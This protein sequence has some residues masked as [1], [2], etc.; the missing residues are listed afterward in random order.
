MSRRRGLWTIGGIIVPVLTLLLAG[1]VWAAPPGASATGGEPL[2]KPTMVSHA[3]F[4]GNTIDC[5]MTNNGA[6]VDSRVYSSSAMM[7]P[8]GTDKFI[9]Y[10]S[11]LWLLGI[12]HD[13]GAIYSAS[14]EYSSELKEGPWPYANSYADNEAYRIYKINGDGTGDWDVWPVDQGAP[15]DENGDPL[16]IGDQTMWWVC[17]DAN[18]TQHSVFL[19]SPPMDVEVHVMVFGFNLSLIHI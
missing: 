15:V 9:D 11:G 17:N 3:H 13:D 5:L 12:G 4:D 7:W 6:I 19:S 14:T 10:A 16:L 2:A 18:E 8:R 1:M